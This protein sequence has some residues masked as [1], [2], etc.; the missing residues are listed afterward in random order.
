MNKFYQSFV[1]NVN[2]H[3][4]QAGLTSM[5]VYLPNQLHDYVNR[6]LVRLFIKSYVRFAGYTKTHV[7]E[8][9]NFMQRLLQDQMAQG[10]AV[11]RKGSIKEDGYL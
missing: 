7:S 5:D 9:T 4:T 3:S 6:K 8:A 1:L 2:N 10:G 11:A